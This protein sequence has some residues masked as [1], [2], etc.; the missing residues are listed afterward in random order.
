MATVDHTQPNRRNLLASAALLPVALPSLGA[1]SEA[2]PAVIACQR[3]HDAEKARGDILKRYDELELPPYPK[4]ILAV[5]RDPSAPGA[6]RVIYA[7]D[8]HALTPAADKP[9]AFI[10]RDYAGEMPEAERREKYAR[11]SAA[12][13]KRNKVVAEIESEAGVAAAAKAAWAAEDAAIATR[14]TTVAGMRAKIACA[15]RGLS[16]KGPECLNENGARAM[17]ESLDAD[18]ERMA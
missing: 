3:W 13:E 7:V 6:E 9:G 8:L 11:L 14:A 5:V 2:D 1:A 4:E 16:G 15:L 17:L 10:G 18:L 12:L